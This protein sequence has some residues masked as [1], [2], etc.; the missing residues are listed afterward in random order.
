MSLP[1]KYNSIST[2]SD[3]FNENFSE[4]LSPSEKTTDSQTIP[5]IVNPMPTLSNVSLNSHYLGNYLP[6]KII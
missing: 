4:I 6:N 1:S 5:S 3:D 2:E